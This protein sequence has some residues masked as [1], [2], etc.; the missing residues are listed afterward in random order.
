MSAL[1]FELK[2]AL[3]A[4]RLAKFNGRDW[5]YQNYPKP[6]GQMRQ[7]T[8]GFLM[9]EGAAYPVKPLGRLANEIAGSPMV[10]NPI[11]NVFR[12]HF[13]QLGFQL[14]ETP[15]DEA[16]GAAERQRRLAKAWARP[17]QAEFRRRVFSLFGARCLVTGCETLKALESAHVLP[18][19]DGGGDEPWNGIPLRADI[20][21]LFDAGA[22]RLV[23]DT[24]KIEVMEPERRDYGDYHGLN[25]EPIMSQIGSA[26][27]LAAALRK[28]MGRGLTARLRLAPG[29]S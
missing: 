29:S 28:R 2:H 8:T 5:L 27:L 16:E 11:T 3:E 18:V 14:I 20:H 23:P 10:E 22:I 26:P 19:A 25:L 12:R 1:I 9:H 7:S 15:E 13:E 24:W 4:I 6:S 21:R 17:G